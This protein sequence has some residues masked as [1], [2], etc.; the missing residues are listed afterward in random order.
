[1]LG[2]SLLKKSKYVKVLF[3]NKLPILD[4]QTL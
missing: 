1:M 3:K 4:L 2:L